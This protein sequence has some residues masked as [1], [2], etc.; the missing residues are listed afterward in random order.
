MIENEKK[1]CV[2]EAIDRIIQSNVTH[3][4][5]MCTDMPQCN[6]FSINAINNNNNACKLYECCN[7]AKIKDAK[8]RKTIYKKT[9]GKQNHKL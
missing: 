6:F 9:K 7:E 5:A 3:C 8:Y 4:K 2:E 1:G